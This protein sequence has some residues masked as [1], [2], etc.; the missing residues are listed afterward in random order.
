MGVPITSG[1]PVF[2]GIRPDDRPERMSIGAK[3]PALGRLRPGLLMGGKCMCRGRSGIVRREGRSHCCLLL[4]GPGRRGSPG[5]CRGGLH[6]RDL[7]GQTT[8]GE[9]ADQLHSRIPSPATLGRV[10]L[11]PM[12]ENAVPAGR[13]TAEPQKK[14]APVRGRHDADDIRRF[15]AKRGSPEARRRGEGWEE[16]ATGKNYCQTAAVSRYT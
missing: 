11:V 1:F 3:A 9:R 15:R 13:R 10:R 6:K 5:W 4:A 8:T 16:P 12:L 14:A 2:G 7:P